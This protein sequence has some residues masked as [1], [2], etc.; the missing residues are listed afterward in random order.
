MGKDETEEDGEDEND[1]DGNYEKS[2]SE[3]KQGRREG[4]KKDGRGGGGREQ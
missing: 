4:V 1:D 2:Q 3:G